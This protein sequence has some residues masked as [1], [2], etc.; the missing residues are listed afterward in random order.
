[1]PAA[2]NRTSAADLGIDVSR[3]DPETFRWLVACLLFATRIK[4]ELAAAAFG[5]LDAADLTS[6]AALAGADWQHVVDLLGS[7]HYKRYDESKARQL[8]QLGRDV[9]EHHDGRLSRL[10]EGLGTKKAARERLQE[11][12]GIGPTAADIFLREVW[13]VWRA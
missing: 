5:E 6:P 7:G 1:M 12:T 9:Q 8:I 4:Q 10:A 2:K 3:G 13:P 11:F